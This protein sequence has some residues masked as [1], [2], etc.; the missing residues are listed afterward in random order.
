MYGHSFWRNILCANIFKV[1]LGVYPG[2]IDHINHRWHVCTS[3]KG[4]ETNCPT[5]LPTRSTTSCG[6]RTGTSRGLWGCTQQE[7]W[8]GSWIIW[9]VTLL[10]KHFLVNNKG[11][12]ITSFI[13]NTL[14]QNHTN[15]DFIPTE[16]KERD[17]IT[18][19]LQY[20]LNQLQKHCKECGGKLN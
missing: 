16:E 1:N 9:E 10:F 18:L 7:V 11:L 8:M 17:K 15:I 6:D 19:T 13:Q 20:L 14:I 3:W 12:A 5:T 2:P 4:Q